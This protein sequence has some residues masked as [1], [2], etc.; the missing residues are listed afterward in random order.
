MVINVIVVTLLPEIVIAFL[1]PSAMPGAV[2]CRGMML[3][4]LLSDLEP[5]ARHC[6][7]WRAGAIRT[8]V[9]ELVL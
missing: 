2:S 4:L 5:R 3:R 1:R 8:G 6:R 9:S 7:S